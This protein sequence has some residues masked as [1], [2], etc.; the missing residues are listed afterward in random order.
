[1]DT[2]SFTTQAADKHGAEIEVVVYPTDTPTT[3][4]CP[5]YTVECGD[6][7]ATARVNNPG[8]VDVSPLCD[9]DGIECPDATLRENVRSAVISG[10]S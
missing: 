7:G 1:M 2:S 6:F 4:T 3:S 10:L 5:E 8:D 9:I